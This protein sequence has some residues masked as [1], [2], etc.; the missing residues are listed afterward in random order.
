MDGDHLVVQLLRHHQD[1]TLRVQV[2][3]LGALWLQAAVDGVHQLTVGICILRAD[4][5]DVL[6]R[7]GVLRNPHLKHTG[8]EEDT[9]QVK[10]REK[11]IE[12]K[13]QPLKDGL[14]N[15]FLDFDFDI[16]I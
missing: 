5:Q 6:P 11:D 12:R 3:E 1:S 7:R 13:Q 15:K 4:L 9:S 14:K 2:E 8:T 10:K 16:S